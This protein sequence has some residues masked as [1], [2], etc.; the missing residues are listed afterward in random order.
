MARQGNNIFEPFT[1]KVGSIVGTTWRGTAVLRSAPQKSDKKPSAAQ[2]LQRLK[3]RML[4]EFLHPIK[5]FLAA[6]F[7][8]MEGS[9]SPFDLALSYHLKE[10]LKIEDETPQINYVKVCISKGHLRG[11]E[12]ATAKVHSENLLQVQWRD[13]SAQSFAS[14]DDML[15]IA[16]FVPSIASFYFF[17]NIALR[18]DKTT[19]LTLPDNAIGVEMHAWATFVS[20]TGFQAATSSY[21]LVAKA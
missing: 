9:K 11:V 20:F 21:I 12:G 8:K 15:T 16:L 17:E 5:P 19:E 14:P 1:G 13:N 10:A 6:R 2:L 4:M 7:G 18:Q 3:F